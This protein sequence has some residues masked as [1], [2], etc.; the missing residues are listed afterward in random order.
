MIFFITCITV[1]I[2]IIMIVIIS[3][4]EDVSYQLRQIQHN[5]QCIELYVKYIAQHK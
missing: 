5:Q 4:G 3:I 1:S 2:L